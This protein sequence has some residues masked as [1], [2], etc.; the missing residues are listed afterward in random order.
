MAKRPVRTKEARPPTNAAE[1]PQP[2]QIGTLNEGPLHAA[3]KALYRRPGDELEVA[4]DGYVVD[5]LRGDQIIE[6]QTAGFASIARKM[7]DLVE[8]HRVRL[9]HP[10]AR[11]RWIVKLP[12]DGKGEPGRRKSPKGMGFE[13]IFEELVSFPELLAHENFELEVALT[14]EEEV[15][16][17]DKRRA[18]RRQHWVVVERRLLE[19]ADR[20]LLQG[21]ADLA[22]LL[23][24]DVP[25]PFQTSDLAKAYRRPRG[26]AQ[27]VA[28]CL[29]HCG[30]IAQT[31]KV[32]NAI[33]YSR[34]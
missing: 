32:G 12:V 22:A 20:R 6:I 23:P 16:R 13:G 27:K 4:V 29:K 33:I 34:A 24:Q 1:I 9:V 3:L 21:P 14:R 19:V 15:R 17:F 11:E 2:S 30:M 8:R 31:G 10:V 25:E 7:R 28:Y 5:I 18:W 26:F